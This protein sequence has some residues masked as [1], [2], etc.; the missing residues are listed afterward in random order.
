MDF[1]PDEWLVF[2]AADFGTAQA[3]SPGEHGAEIMAEIRANGRIMD[4]WRISVGGSSALEVD[5][6][7]PDI[8]PAASALPRWRFSYQ[9]FPRD[10]VIRRNMTSSDWID[11]SNLL[12]A[13]EF[14]VTDPQGEP[15]QLQVIQEGLAGLSTRS[16]AGASIRWAVVAA[17]SGRLELQLQSLP[18]SATSLKGKPILQR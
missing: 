3:R 9:V 2:A 8:Y 7:L 5:F 1:P 11:F 18:A 4:H 12:A 16:S 10:V 6:H 15:V 13:N 14:M 17:A